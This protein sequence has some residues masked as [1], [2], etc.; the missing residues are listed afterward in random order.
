MELKN[1]K[2]YRNIAFKLTS[3]LQSKTSEEEAIR[4]LHRI[5][6]NGGQ[7]KD[8]CYDGNEVDDIIKNEN[9]RKHTKNNR[10]E[11]AHGNNE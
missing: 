9:R 2:K 5:G 7:L 10:S 11:I 4:T 3:F 8:L 6:L 1:E